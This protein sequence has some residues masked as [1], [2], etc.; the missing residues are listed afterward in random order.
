MLSIPPHLTLSVQVLLQRFNTGQVNVDLIQLRLQVLCE[1]SIRLKVSLQLD[2]H[3]VRL[4]G[5]IDC[6]LQ[7]LL[8]C[9]LFLL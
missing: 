5:A 8:I 9:D 4:I 2:T 1:L 6:F 7:R 3:P